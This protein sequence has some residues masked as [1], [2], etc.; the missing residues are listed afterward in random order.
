M[1]TSHAMPAKGKRTPAAAEKSPRHRPTMPVVAARAPPRGQKLAISTSDT[2]DDAW[3]RSAQG[4]G[5]I[6]RQ[7]GEAGR[8]AVRAGALRVP[9]ECG[10]AHRAAQPKSPSAAACVAALAPARRGRPALP[11]MGRPGGLAAMPARPAS[12][13]KREQRVSRASQD[14]WRGRDGRGFALWCAPPIDDGCR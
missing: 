6:T 9:H 2:C 11:P 13:G 10:A 14:G 12:D 5:T 7:P 1:A 3:R 4:P 8:L